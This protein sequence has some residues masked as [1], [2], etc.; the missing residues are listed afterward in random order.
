MDYG[1]K[2][3][4]QDENQKLWSTDA[5]GRPAESPEVVLADTTSFLFTRYLIA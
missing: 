5:D 4:Y 3:S 1:I 2:F